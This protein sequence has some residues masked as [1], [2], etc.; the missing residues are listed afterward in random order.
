MIVGR[1]FTL[2][3]VKNKTTLRFYHASKSLPTVVRKKGAYEFFYAD[4]RVLHHK[5]FPHTLIPH[6]GNNIS[7]KFMDEKNCFFNIDIFFANSIEAMH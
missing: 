5:K 6:I 3:L 4:T 2:V 1:S 7:G